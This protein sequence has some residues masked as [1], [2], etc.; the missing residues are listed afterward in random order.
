M[1]TPFSLGVSILATR[2]GA[3]A[4]QVQPKFQARAF[5][6]DERSAGG[7]FPSALSG[8]GSVAVLT[9]PSVACYASGITS[10]ESFGGPPAFL[11]Q[12]R[13]MRR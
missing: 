3:A 4:E 1:P 12:A 7:I 9:R 2:T 11:L 6:R 8:I 13:L 10:S 5:Q